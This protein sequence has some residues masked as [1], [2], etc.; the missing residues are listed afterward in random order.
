MAGYKTVMASEGYEFRITRNEAFGADVDH[1]TEYRVENTEVCD[2]G[3]AKYTFRSREAGRKIARL[4]PTV[5]LVEIEKPE[6][7]DYASVGMGK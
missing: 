6:A 3:Y 1:T 2:C 5:E 4:D 7:T